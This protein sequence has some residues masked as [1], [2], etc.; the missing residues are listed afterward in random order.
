[1]WVLGHFGIQAVVIFLSFYTY[2]HVTSAIIGSI[3]KPL[4]SVGIAIG[5]LGSS[6]N[7][8]GKFYLKLNHKVKKNF[9]R[10]WFIGNL[11]FQDS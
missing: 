7:V 11:I 6:Y 4:F 2:S 3:L 9:H 8:G 1:M 10:G 5:T